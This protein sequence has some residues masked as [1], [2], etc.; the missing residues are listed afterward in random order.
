MS[1]SEAECLEALL[2]GAE[3]L[4]RTPTIG[5]I[6]FLRAIPFCEYDRGSVWNMAARPR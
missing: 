6:R 4:E 2:E 3:Q 5:G 1:Y